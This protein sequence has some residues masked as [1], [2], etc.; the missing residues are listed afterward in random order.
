ME[1]VH[2]HTC[3]CIHTYVH[4]FVNESLRYSHMS[5]IPCTFTYQFSLTDIQFYCQ[6]QSY[7]VLSTCGVLPMCTVVEAEL[8]QTCTALQILRC[9]FILCVL[10]I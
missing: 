6:L 2:V 9:S 10:G 4:A 5:V 1:C 8:V 7:L 3:E